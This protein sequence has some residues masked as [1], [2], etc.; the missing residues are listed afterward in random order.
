MEFR[1]KWALLWVICNIVFAYVLNELNKEGTEEGEGSNY[2]KEI[3]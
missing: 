2:K 3:P 1:T